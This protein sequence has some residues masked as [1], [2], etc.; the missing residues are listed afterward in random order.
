M[1]RPSL[2]GDRARQRSPTGPILWDHEAD[3][4]GP[5]K[6]FPRDQPWD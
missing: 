5:H 1:G 6:P 2:W 3:S 4:V